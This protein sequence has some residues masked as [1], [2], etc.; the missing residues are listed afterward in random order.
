MEVNVNSDKLWKGESLL[1]KSGAPG[2]VTGFGRR[3]HVV[4]HP[5]VCARLGHASLSPSHPEATGIQNSA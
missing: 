2:L 5:D 1:Q 3:G 4:M